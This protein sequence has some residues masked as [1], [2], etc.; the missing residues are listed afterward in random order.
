MAKVVAAL[1]PSGVPVSADMPAQDDF[2]DP[3]LGI[4]PG[5]PGPIKTLQTLTDYISGKQVKATAEEIE[6]V[7]VFAR[8][9]VDDLGYPKSHIQTRP[10]YRVRSTPSGGKT[11][12][13]PIDIAVF[14]SAKK[15][16]FEISIIVEC[17]RKNRKDGEEQLKIYMRMAPSAKTGV[18]F[19][20][21]DHLY[22]LGNRPVAGQHCRLYLGSGSRSKI[23]ESGYAERT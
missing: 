22:L 4:E 9:L 3:S 7:Q 16:E 17:K 12:G 6:A 18:W 5:T 14:A 10:Q 8:K 1:V 11:K 2:V 20:G 23:S 15:L 13:Y 21:K 19:N